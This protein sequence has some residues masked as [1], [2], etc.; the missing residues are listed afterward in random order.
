MVRLPR[1]YP[2]VLF[3]CAIAAPT[4]FA[5]EWGPR[6]LMAQEADE[7]AEAPAEEEGDAAA[8]GDAA[9]DDASE[10][11]AAAEEGEGEAMEAEGE[12]A[13]AEEG[14]GEAMDAAEGDDAGADDTETEGDTET[15][16][17]EE[18]ET[19]EGETAEAPPAAESVTPADAPLDVV[20]D[21]FL[22]YGTLARYDVAA[23]E[24]K[25]L[26]DMGKTPKEVL[27]S[28]EK[29]MAVRNKG[30]RPIS[31]DQMLIT[32]GGAEQTK[33]V[34]KQIIEVLNEARRGRMG[35]PKFIDQA[36]QD[37]IVNERSYARAL[38]L[39]KQS[40]ELAVPQM[41]D[42]L[43]DPRKPEYHARV[44]RALI[45][46][47]R[48]VLNPL[49]ASL[50]M[51][52]Q[53]ALVMVVG[54]LADL[55]YESA[56]PYIADLRTRRDSPQAVREAAD[57]ALRNLNAQQA[58]NQVADLYYGQA[59]SFYAG[60]NSIR[61]DPHWKQAFIWFIGN[62][63][64]SR[65][66]VPH[67]IFDEVMAM[68]TAKRA[69]ELQTE[70]DAQSLWLAANY[71]REAQLP[72]G[73]SDPTA[74]VDSAHFYG[75]DSGTRY[76]NAVLSRALRDRD[77]AVAL[78]A[79]KSLQEIIGGANM[80]AGEVGQP[81]IDGMRSPDRL[82]RFESAFAVASALPV[83]EFAGR[84]RVVPLL[85]EAV[86]QSGKANVL[87]V[88]GEDEARTRVMGELKGFSVAGATGLDA[89][90]S[91]AVTLPT[92]DVIVVTKEVADDE[93]ARLIQVA[94]QD[95]RLDRAAK[96]IVRAE[97]A[98]PLER[99]NVR[100]KDITFTQA[101]DGA[102]LTKL[103][104]TARARAGG[105]PLDAAV[106]TEYALR[107]ARL[108]N[109]IAIAKGATTLDTRPAEQVLLNALADPRPEVAKEVAATLAWINSPLVQ[110]A[111]LAVTQQDKTPPDVRVA[112]FKALA[113]NAK[114]FGNQLQ[115]PQ[116]A[117]VQ[118]VVQAG[119]SP[120]LRNAAAEAAGALNLPGDQAR[121]LI[122]LWS[123][124]GA[125]PAASAQANP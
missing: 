63:G 65:K 17:G 70:R 64:L 88:A 26:L 125:A 45:D 24:G 117:V 11:D 27:E 119:D 86:S 109:A 22:H 49:V 89:A 66:E 123:V 106:A 91:E 29:V 75:V 32:W 87:V 61:S 94:S 41:V 121:R 78:R 4:L 52:D 60:T 34:S 8:E 56:V 43:R 71:R 13:A 79:V 69:L 12:D 97:R 16:E 103:I 92:I 112:L 110:P 57:T 33:D 30:R 35:D 40:G 20:A 84:E 46:M 39:L 53:D 105:A 44:Q 108:L 67:G 2:A 28:F 101:E 99:A 42:Y 76:L 19:A 80:A 68:R 114:N 5:P 7:E 47:G 48:V 50:E 55:G 18:G 83:G 10:G 102:T 74:P 122:L 104:E 118:N 90:I 115:Q 72:Q 93:A 98:T 100:R 9:G 6:V 59:E 36:I 25:K 3:A 124:Q 96:V 107:G 81:L 51:K 120:E 73:A 85:A 15:A 116:F 95:G 21:A 58:A 113:G 31:L 38:A 111:L 62:S 37:L 23:I 77:A 54:V 1:L 82:V 14:E